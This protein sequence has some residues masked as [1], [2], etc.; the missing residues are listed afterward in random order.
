MLAATPPSQESWLGLQVD[1]IDEPG[2]EGVIVIDVVR[3]SPANRAG[4]QEGDVIT[5]VYSREVTSLK[6]YVEISGK[7]K[8]R[9]EPIAFLI[10]RERTSRY[11]PVIPEN[12]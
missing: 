6:D 9:K 1:E 8:D 2:Q 4:I 10:R 5:E 3:G 7:L 11:V 12:N